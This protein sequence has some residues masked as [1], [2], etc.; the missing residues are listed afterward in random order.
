M[1][2]KD[3][4]NQSIKNLFMTRKEDGQP[5]SEF[6]LKMENELLPSHYSMQN[7]LRNFWKGEINLKM[8]AIE[9]VCALIDLDDTEGAKN[10][11]S[12]NYYQDF[13]L[14]NIVGIARCNEHFQFMNNYQFAKLLTSFVENFAES[15][16][17]SDK[18]R[19]CIDNIFDNE[20]RSFFYKQIMVF[21][22]L[23]VVPYLTHL[24][25]SKDV[26]TDRVLLGV[27]LLGWL[28]IYSI[29]LIAMRVEGFRTYV[30]NPW[31]IMD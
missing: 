26:T 23:F 29:E 4:P 21:G 24:F 8:P 17:Q 13:D 14:F 25:V 9:N 11:K 5:Q 12:T 31:N 28:C 27:A 3:K 15:I 20:T 2:S 18:I 1:L 16:E 19:S 22:S 7:Y 6:W 30:S 10:I